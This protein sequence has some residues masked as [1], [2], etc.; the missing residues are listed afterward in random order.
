MHP[1]TALPYYHLKPNDATGYRMIL[2][3]M[4]SFAL[5]YDIFDF[6]AWEWDSNGTRRESGLEIC[7]TC[8]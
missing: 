4:S 7:H 8:H 5:L 3:L 6:A 1:V 2:S